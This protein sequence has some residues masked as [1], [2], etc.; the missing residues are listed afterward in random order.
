M[1]GWKV[2]VFAF[3]LTA[4]ASEPG[5]AEVVSGKVQVVD[6]DTIMISHTT[7]RLYGI[8]APETGQR[9]AAANR[10]ISRPSVKAI[11][12]LKAISRSGLACEGS[13]VDDYNRLIARCTTNDGTDINRLLVVEGHAWAFVKYAADYSAEEAKARAQGL[14]IWSM[15]CEEPWVFRQKRW[16]KNATKAPEGCAIKGNIGDGGKIY[17]MPWNKAYARTVIDKA[18][19]E[20]WFCNEREAQA[21][22][23]RP[24]QN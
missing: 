23:W 12:R 22:G 14:N 18:R 19:G 5:V 15:R 1:R 3:M 21:A 10:K 6:G 2:L 13:E 16:T 24:A 20:A 4:V 9:C 11:A 17:H 8:D 7:I